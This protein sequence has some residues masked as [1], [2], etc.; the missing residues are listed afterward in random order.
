MTAWLFEWSA[1]VLLKYEV[2]GNGRTRYEDI[3]GHRVRHK[4]L[5]FGEHI[6]FMLAKD[7]GHRNK[8]DQEWMSGF[9]AGGDRTYGRV[10]GDQGGASVQ[11]PNGSKPR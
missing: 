9:F 8:Y 3:K 10:R 11:M 1:E 6:H 7:E 2:R 5:G 4:V